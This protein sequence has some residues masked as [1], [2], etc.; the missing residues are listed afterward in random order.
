MGSKYIPETLNR[1]YFDYLTLI[2]LGYLRIFFQ[3]YEHIYSY[4]A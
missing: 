2:W 1:F 3:F 4:N